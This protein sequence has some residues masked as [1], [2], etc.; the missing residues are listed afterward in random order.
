MQYKNF[1][2]KSRVN[3]NNK[4]EISVM[5]GE[6]VRLEEFGDFYGALSG[7]FIVHDGEKRII[8]IVTSNKL[9]F[10]ANKVRILLAEEDTNID[11]P[12]YTNKLTYDWEL[13][14]HLPAERRTECLDKGKFIVNKAGRSL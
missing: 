8:D 11:I 7:R 6:T 5:Q 1:E 12:T 13:W 2:V 3:I 4:G 10:D 14:I 9:V